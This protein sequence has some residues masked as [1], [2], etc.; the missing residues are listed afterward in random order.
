MSDQDTV[1][2]AYSDTLKK[3]YGFFFDPF[4]IAKNDNDRDQ[5]KQRFKTGLDLARKSRDIALAS[6]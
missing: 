3:L 4:A 2:A 6:L 5:A 1:K